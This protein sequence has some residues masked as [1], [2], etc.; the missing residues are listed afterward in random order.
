MRARFPAFSLLEAA[1]GEL[2]W[3]GVIAPVA[4]REF[5]IA[6]RYPA[7]YPYTEPRLF[8]EQPA[9]RAGAPHRYQDESLCIHRTQW[10]PMTG[11][12]ASCVPLAAAWLLNYVVWADTE[13]GA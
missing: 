11:T 6:V 13:A 9:L 4:G 2:R 7:N 10:N 3:V 5:L 12:A 1:G 8:V